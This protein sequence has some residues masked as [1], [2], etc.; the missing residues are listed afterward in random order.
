[1]QV[2]VV[3]TAAT[4]VDSAT[5]TWVM[6][7]YTAPARRNTVCMPLA[8]SPLPQNRDFVSLRGG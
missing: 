3:L 1:M 2:W 5:R 7:H 6:L 8:T 4:V